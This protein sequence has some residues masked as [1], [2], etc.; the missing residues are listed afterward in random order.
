MITIHRCFNQYVFSLYIQILF[1]FE[2]L[3]LSQKQKTFTNDVI[4]IEIPVPFQILAMLMDFFVA[5]GANSNSVVAC[6]VWKE[7]L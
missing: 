6:R 3:Q 1:S 7:E 4:C 2:N 5:F